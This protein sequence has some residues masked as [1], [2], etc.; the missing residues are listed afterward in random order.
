MKWL[1]PTA[2][3]RIGAIVLVVGVL[4][5][6]ACSPEEAV[7][8]VNTTQMPVTVYSDGNNL[9]TL[10]PGES[11]AFRT[12][13]NLMPDRIQVYGESGDLILDE[14]VTWEALQQRD[15]EITIS[16]DELQTS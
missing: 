11:K 13:E 2:S 4:V 12:R 1:G 8:Y 3:T 6:V 5:S 10:E 15:F 9:A 14:I 16:L 7:T